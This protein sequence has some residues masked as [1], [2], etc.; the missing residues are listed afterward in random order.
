MKFSQLPQPKNLLLLGLLLG[1]CLYTVLTSFVALTAVDGQ[2]ATILLTKT[3]YAGF[4][5][6]A[7]CI[8]SY[9]VAHQFFKRALGIML[10][11]SVFHLVNFLPISFTMGLGFGE[12]KV[13]VDPVNLLLLVGYYFLNRTSA[14][15][16]IRK[17]LLP[18]P[19]PKKVAHLRRESIDQF[20]QNF[21]RKTDESL[22]Q[23][24][25]ERKLVADA[26][27]AAHELLQERK[28]IITPASQ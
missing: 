3:N 1:L 12:L 19:T 7:V 26:V 28:A 4:I 23:I 20:K 2:Y 16:F 18:A 13:G 15:V 10:L 11:L 8:L 22:R 25:H 6:V 24:V 27:T 5:A 21:T 9:F 14:N 17:Y